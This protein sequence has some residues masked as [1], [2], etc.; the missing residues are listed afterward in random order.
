MSR[1]FSQRRHI[2]ITD[3]GAQ[4]CCLVTKCQWHVLHTDLYE[5]LCTLL[6]SEYKTW[7]VLYDGFTF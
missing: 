5:N 7:V 6:G 4:K 3:V 1:S 2:G